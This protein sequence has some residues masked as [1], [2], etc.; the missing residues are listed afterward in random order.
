MSDRLCSKDG[1]T[2][3]FLARNLCQLHYQRATF[4]PTHSSWGAM[5]RRCYDKNFLGYEKYGGRGITV[6]DR[7]LD[8]KNFLADM[9]ERPD[10]MSIDRIDVNGNYEPSNCRWADREAQNHNQ[11]RRADNTSGIPGVNWHT[12]QSKWVARISIR[13]KRISLGYFNNLADAELAYINAKNK[14]KESYGIV[15][16]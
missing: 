4:S 9:G 13:G 7:W 14:V 2:R 3:K 1:C 8:Y 10:S 11:N 5:K 12:K 15:H 16:A 6:C